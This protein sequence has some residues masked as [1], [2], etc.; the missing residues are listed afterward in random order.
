MLQSFRPRFECRNRGKPLSCALSRL[1][2]LACSRGE[3]GRGKQSHHV[4][5]PK[6]PQNLKCA[7]TVMS[8]TFRGAY[9]AYLWP[10]ANRATQ[11]Q[12]HLSQ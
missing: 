7:I 12:L 5:N 10:C 6:G 1:F 11:T 3:A 8:L 4:Q 2:S 9:H